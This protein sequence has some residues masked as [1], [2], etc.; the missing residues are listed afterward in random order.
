M[1][2]FVQIR[3]LVAAGLLL[4]ALL[5]PAGAAAALSLDAPGHAVANGAPAVVRGGDPGAEWRLFD[6]RGRALGSGAF[7]ADGTAD[8][9]ARPLGYYRLRA[10]GGTVSFAVVQPPEKGPRP[11]SFFGV[12]SAQSWLAEPGKFDC[13]WL[14]GDALRLVSDLVALSGVSHVR[15][16]LGAKETNPRPGVYDFSRY[17]RGA[18]LL[19]ARGVAVTSV[20][21]DVP[22]HLDP[23]RKLPRDLAALHAYCREAAATFGER[24]DAWE[25]WNEPDASY[26][27][28]PVWDFAAAF[29]A[30]SLGFKAG[31]PEASVLFGALCR[32]ARGR[33]DRMLVA[34]DALGYADAYNLHVY[35]PL[36]GLP[37]FF[38]DLR[39]FLARAHAPDL[40]V[41]LTENGSN[42][43]GPAAVASAR[44]GFK[45]H[46][47]DQELVQAEAYAK[48]Q[49]LFQMNGVARSYAFVFGAYGERNGEK[50]WGALRRDG[51][52][53]PVFAAIATATRLLGRARPEGELAV[54]KGSRAFLYT[55]PD[56]SQT[57][58][59]WTLSEA[60]TAG[61][62]APPVASAPDGAAK[63]RLPVASGR[64]ALTDLCG[65]TS[66]VRSNA[67]PA[68][69][70]PAYLSGLRGLKAKVRA[71]PPGRLGAAA[72]A[73]N[74]DR[75]IV[76][77][78]DLDPA[79]FRISGQ[80]T[81]ADL[82]GDTG[83]LRLHVWNLSDRPKRGCVRAAGGALSGVPE[84]IELPAMGEAAFDCVYAPADGAGASSRLVLAGRF[85]GRRTT[86]L[87]IDVRHM[88]TIFATSRRIDLR[89]WREAKAWTRNTS[90]DSFSASWDEAEGAI[91]FDAAWSAGK[92]RWL[93]PAY[94]LAAAGDSLAGAEFLEFEV[95]S[96]Q[97]RP[98][99]AFKCARLMLAASGRGR[100]ETRLAFDAPTA[101]WETRIVSL[102]DVP[103]L[104]DCATLRLGANPRG[105]RCTIW[106]R[107]LRVGK[108]GTDLQRKQTRKGQRP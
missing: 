75:S 62:G 39:G 27:P 85:D 35:L 42:L 34:N 65:A 47:E 11:A 81:T 36:S 30:A 94:S 6:W 107:N 87:V 78:A 66:E 43:E 93:Y 104:G 91:R 3:R 28:E 46:S 67:V 56:G 68:S 64:Y 24:L 9:G 2:R 19:R 41:W 21:H 84:E 45:A 102:S 108:P 90:A 101:E 44:A 55:Q 31:R 23:I 63:L 12:D 106:V 77:R 92:D 100:K 10:S 98:E 16:R 83:R 57:V 8:L 1:I 53:K 103:D 97:D 74:E 40:A 29:K 50:D 4:G 96:E 105:E 79:D 99:N 60:D 15:D 26:A 69:R 89:R 33:Y 82:Q 51:T 52:V 20:F 48:S 80:K 25:F 13:P 59:F 32:P 58:V 49:V 5:A 71:V 14:D 76:L 61:E 17:L 70:F 72:P 73:A 7:S 22:A 54:G 88:K 18:D 86:R 95:R 38:G 37:A